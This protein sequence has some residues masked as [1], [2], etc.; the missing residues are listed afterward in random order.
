MPATHTRYSTESYIWS[1]MHYSQKKSKPLW[2]FIPPTAVPVSIPTLYRAVL[3]AWSLEVPGH[4]SNNA[5]L[6][7]YPFKIHDCVV[8]NS[9]WVSCYLSSTKRLKFL[10]GLLLLWVWFRPTQQSMYM[11]YKYG[12]WI[13]LWHNIHHGVV[14]I[15]AWSIIEQRTFVCRL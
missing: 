9:S 4:Q 15:M 8:N 14:L 10:I 1:T 11:V 2:L 5:Q 6:Y 13:V 3:H 7:I 12:F